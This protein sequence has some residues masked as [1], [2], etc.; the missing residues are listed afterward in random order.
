MGQTDATQLTF[1]FIDLAGFTAL[2]EAMGDEEAAGVAE[3]FAALSREC[4]DEQDRFVKSIGDAVM[5]ASP[6]PHASLMLTGRLL[7]RV[8][9]EANFPIPR[10]GL[11]HGG[12]VQRGDDFFGASV[13]LAARV[14]AQ[15]FGGQVLATAAVAEEARALGITV[16]DLGG[17]SFKNVSD[18]VELF[19]VHVGPRM[20]GG[21]IDPVCRMRVERDK[22]AGRLRFG[23]A[24]HWFCS[25]DC[26]ARFATSPASYAGE[27]A[28]S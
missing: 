2:T 17:F 15:A 5:L 8:Y 28:S 16:V 10:A 18:E 25:L 13:N 1:I 21:A 9:A 23:S 12:A 11:H 24:D 6:S 26:A 3:R 19:E 7:D 4:L 22:A 27:E 20:A 14:A